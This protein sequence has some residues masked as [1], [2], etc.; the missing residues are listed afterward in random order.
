MIRVLVLVALVVAAAPARAAVVTRGPYLQTNTTIG[1]I[2]RW[3]TDVATDSRVQ[4]GAAPGSLTTN[5]DDA[6]VTTEHIVPVTG[7]TAYTQYF[8]SIG[9]TSMV[10]AGDDANHFF[11]TSPTSG[12]AGAYRFWVTGDGGFATGPQAPNTIAVRDAYTTFQG[13]AETNLFLLLGDNAYLVGSDADYQAAFFD[14][15]AALLRNTPAWP[16]FGNHEAFSSNSLTQTGPYFAMFSLPT[17]GEAGGDP[18]GSEAYFSFDYGNIH[19]INLDG[20]S[21]PVTAGS[22]MMTWLEADLQATSADWV[23]AFWHHPPYSKGLVHDSDVELRE[24]ALRE[25]VVPM[26]ED[27]GVDLVMCGHSHSY[28]RSYLL[29]GHYDFSPTFDPAMSLDS[30]DGDAAGDGAYRKEALGPV[31]HDGAVYMVAGS[32]SEVRIATLNHPAHRIGLLEH[33]SVVLDVNGATLTAQFL[34]SAGAITDTFTI[35]K[36]V[37]A[38]C[39]AAPRGG[40]GASTSGKLVLKD[41]TDDSYDKFVWKWKNGTLDAGEVGTPDQQTDLA[42]CVY[43]ANGSLVGGPVPPGADVSGLAAWRLISGGTRY[44]DTAGV[45]VGITKVKVVPG[46]GSGQIL[47]KGRG[48]TLGMPTLPAVL[49]LTAQLVNLDNDVC[50]ETAFATARVNVAGRVVAQQ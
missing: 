50:W 29:D 10:L 12:T 19:F 25:N 7:L 34:N 18:S 45:A 39:P 2:V 8:Y 11:R 23:I 3:R 48:A 30:G 13:G 41:F 47:A 28:E 36:G 4:I 46:A 5:I 43:D 20:N 6:T 14:M 37:G 35:R 31:P 22:A 1:V 33:G 32:S 24:I 26:L 27:Y 38:A 16:T 17:A 44:T 9:D 15:H 40:C 42:V 49:P 21:E